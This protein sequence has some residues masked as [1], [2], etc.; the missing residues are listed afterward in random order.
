MALLRRLWTI[1]HHDCR[2]YGAS[3]QRNEDGTGDRDGRSDDPAIRAWEGLRK[4]YM[5]RVIVVL[6]SVFLG[7]TSVA[8]LVISRDN[9][10]LIELTVGTVVLGIVVGIVSSLVH[11]LGDRWFEKHRVAATFLGLSVT[12]FFVAVLIFA[13]NA[14]PRI[15]RKIPVT[16]LVSTPA[17]ELPRR[18][19][20]GDRVVD[21]CYSDAVRIFGA[22][23][24]SRPDRAKLL[25]ELVDQGTFPSASDGHVFRDLT[26]FLVP[27]FLGEGTGAGEPELAA[28][29]KK[30]W[31]L[32]GIPDDQIAG[33]AL[34]LEDIEGPIR[35]NMYFGVQSAFGAPIAIR[36]PKGMTIRLIRNDLWTS[37]YVLENRYL[38]V[39]IGI[40]SLYSKPMSNQSGYP[41]V[42]IVSALSPM[43]P[44]VDGLEREWMGPFI[45]YD[46]IIYFDVDFDRFWYG[47]TQMKYYEEWAES[48][49][50]VLDKKFA[51][52]HPPLVGSRSAS[53]PPPRAVQP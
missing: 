25:E 15:S 35:E 41:Y 33:D 21:F 42:Y 28:Y 11:T 10:R 44:Y 2:C 3:I 45:P 39:R 53:G 7:L 8:Y 5:T 50:S 52:G 47:S 6:V 36:V 37:T 49:F 18:L 12:M 16:Y 26:T 20:F 29:Y 32:V 23:M 14:P 9:P 34:A 30:L 48:V 51:W 19:E 24:A 27:Y 13:S 43:S 22:G 4:R 38:K 17:K 31:P 46:T 40:R 1:V